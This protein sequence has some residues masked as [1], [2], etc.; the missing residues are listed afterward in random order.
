MKAVDASA[1]Q[2][3]A[4][5]TRNRGFSNLRGYNFTLSPKKSA[6]VLK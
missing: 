1:V 5:F 3:R 4:G 2:Q 6:I